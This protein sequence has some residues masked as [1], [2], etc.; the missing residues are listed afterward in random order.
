MTLPLI[1][2]FLA[3]SDPTTY[4]VQTEPPGLSMSPKLE[5]ISGQNASLDG[6]LVS[7]RRAGEAVAAK[8]CRE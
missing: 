7:G 5:T 6:A 1:F 3:C 2:A 4:D 8:L